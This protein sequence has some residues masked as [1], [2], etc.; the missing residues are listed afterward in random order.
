MHNNRITLQLVYLAANLRSEHLGVFVEWHAAEAA[1]LTERLASAKAQY[2]DGMRK[3]KAPSKQLQ[4]LETEIA[5]SEAP[6]SSEFEHAHVVKTV[7]DV[8]CH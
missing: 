7:G 5:G 1:K 4:Y 2:T 3:V 8:C 6:A